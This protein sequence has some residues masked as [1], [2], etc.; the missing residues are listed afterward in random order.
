VSRT[1]TLS[2]T[3]PSLTW[4][5]VIACVLA[6]A[7][8]VPEGPPTPAYVPDAPAAESATDM[9]VTPFFDDFNRAAIGTDY[10]ALG[11]AWHIQNGRLCAEGAKNQPIWLKKR[12][13]VNARIEV[14]AIALSP[15]G[16]LKVE[17]WGDGKSG[18]SGTTYSDATSYIAIF[19]GWKNKLHV[20]ARLD[21]HGDDR[22]S[23]A[24]VP[25]SDDERARPVEP[26]QPYHF[27]IERKNGSTVRFSVNGLDYFAFADPA[28]LTGAGHDHVGFNDW[29]AP[30]CF[31]NFSVSPL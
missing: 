9:L 28:P 30:V 17:A 22:L 6:S 19:G 11:S 16:D 21:E 8:C 18:A 14:D 31:D 20:L 5:R 10:E 13:P 23:L 15:E 1:E 3:L 26:G 27:V 7:G 12:I 4:G 24:I 2:A 29:T 25:G